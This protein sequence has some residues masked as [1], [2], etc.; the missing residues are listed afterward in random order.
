MVNKETG[1]ALTSKQEYDAKQSAQR[2]FT[3]RI[4]T[5]IA[6]AWT[7]VRVIPRPE[8][9]SAPGV[10]RAQIARNPVR[11]DGTGWDAERNARR[12]WTVKKIQYSRF[13]RMSV[14]RR[15]T[16][17]SHDCQND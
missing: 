14:T 10:G 6:N 17:N 3:A 5:R 1:F 13:K 2:V 8:V 12:K 9:A 16:L 4:V 15:N 11:K 7:I